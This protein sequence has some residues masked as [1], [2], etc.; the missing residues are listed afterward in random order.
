MGWPKDFMPALV[1][2]ERVLAAIWS[3]KLG[4]ILNSDIANVTLSSGWFSSELGYIAI[5]YRFTNYEDCKN[6]IDE[7]VDDVLWKH[8][9]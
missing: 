3:Q 9:Q 7:K 1:R 2:E 6:E 8:N 4:S 5:E